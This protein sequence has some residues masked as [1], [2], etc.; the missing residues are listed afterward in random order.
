MKIEGSHDVP[1]PRKKVWDA[2]LDPA[3]L[4]KAIPGCEK[5][6]A[7]GNDEF[8]ATLKVGVAAVKGTFEGKVRLAEKKPPESYRL[9]AE[10]SGGPGF[11]KADTLITLSE[12]EGGTRIAYS[13]DVQVGGLIAG[14]G[15]RML[16]GVSRMMADQFFDKMTQLLKS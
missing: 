7:L 10:G 12:I 5:L 6:E 11:V 8:K 14:V 2:F 15:Q 9:A 1:A 16:G 4:K 13:A 3:Q